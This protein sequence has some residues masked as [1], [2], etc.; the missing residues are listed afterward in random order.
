MPFKI[1]QSS[2]DIMFIQMFIHASDVYTCVHFLATFWPNGSTNGFL[3][4]LGLHRN[5]YK[6]T[7]NILLCASLISLVAFVSM[8]EFE[9]TF[10]TKTWSNKV[11]KL[12]LKEYLNSSKLWKWYTRF[13][14]W[15][16][17]TRY[18]H[19]TLTISWHRLPN[20]DANSQGCYKGQ[21]R[22]RM[23]NGLSLLCLTI[24]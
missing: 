10:S 20:T 18:A 12:H 4:P 15:K 7:L 2:Y 3:F 19:I 9:D 11:I 22:F 16:T 23:K 21:L 8:T 13:S 6:A 24:F 17:P 5:P 14:F 1:N